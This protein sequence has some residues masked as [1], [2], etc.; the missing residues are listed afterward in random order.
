MDTLI[1]HLAKASSVVVDGGKLCSIQLT[2][3]LDMQQH[4][5]I[6]IDGIVEDAVEQ[7]VI[8]VHSRLLGWQGNFLQSQ[9]KKPIN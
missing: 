3:G 5:K 2:I 9:K 7:L 8:K 1:N 6:R 4:T